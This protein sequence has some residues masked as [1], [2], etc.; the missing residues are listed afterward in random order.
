MSNHPSLRDSMAGFVERGEVPGLVAL[1]SR[2]GKLD[3]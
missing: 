2:H 3:A 1:V